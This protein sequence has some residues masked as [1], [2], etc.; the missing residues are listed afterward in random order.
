MLFRSNAVG[1]FFSSVCCSM[2]DFIKTPNNMYNPILIVAAATSVLLFAAC[3][4]SVNFDVYSGYCPDDIV[5]VRWRFYNT[6]SQQISTSPP[7]AG[8]NGPVTKSGS[9]T[10]AAQN[11]N[12]SFRS[13]GNEL[14]EYDVFVISEEQTSSITF[15][16]SGC[17]V[18]EGG[19]PDV[20]RA[21]ALP[22]F[23]P[24]LRIKSIRN[25]SRDRF[26]MLSHGGRNVRLEAGQASSA[27][28]GLSI[29]GE[30]SGDLE[31]KTIL[32]GGAGGI[33]RTEGCENATTVSYVPPRPNQFSVEV[34]IGCE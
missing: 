9:A 6:E 18:T 3:T 16:Y 20:Y 33:A 22:E 24:S 27:F 32:D 1:N 8:L 19:T 12:I 4:P 25:P 23:S 11:V 29:N 30:W 2:S 13:N 28:N 17:V 31:R 10:F 7:I 26:V 15:D 5:E 34:V 21:R 14:E